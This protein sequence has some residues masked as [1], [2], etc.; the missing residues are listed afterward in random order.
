MKS[1]WARRCMS[2]LRTVDRKK[3]FVERDAWV[4]FKYSAL[5]E[6]VG[7]SML[8]YGILADQLGWWGKSFALALGGSIHGMLYLLY[9][10]ILAATYSSLGW[11]RLRALVGFCVSALPY[12]TL[13]FELTRT[14]IRRE[15]MRGSD[16]RMMVRV[17]VEHDGKL[18]AVQEG[19]SAYW[20]LPGA[21]VAAGE[22]AVAAAARVLED[23]TGIAG[24]PGDIRYVYEPKLGE[25]E[26][27]LSVSNVADYAGL[28]L[29]AIAKQHGEVEELAFVDPV[30]APTLEP[31]FLQ[32]GVEQMYIAFSR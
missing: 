9:V 10:G 6:V 19:T 17:V 26:L 31:K 21:Y 14:I 22:L 12:G 15:Q 30:K 28:D 13:F 8:I 3:L 4:L 23:L 5:S 7:W 27:Y 32:T 25:V 1:K 24:E 16:R 20:Q 29:R 18:L 11:T 2:F